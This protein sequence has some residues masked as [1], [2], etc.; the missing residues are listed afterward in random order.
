MFKTSD[1]EMVL[2]LRGIPFAI[3]PYAVRVTDYEARCLHLPSKLR[4][5]G[6]RS[7]D[8][9]PYL[10][11]LIAERSPGWALLLSTPSRHQFQRKGTLLWK[12]ESYYSHISI[13]RIQCKAYF[14]V[15]LSLGSRTLSQPTVFIDMAVKIYEQL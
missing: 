6:W 3:F 11:S 5:S 2:A 12:L 8:T 4:K 9:A 15:R 10:V 14:Y 7:V 13:S 1:E